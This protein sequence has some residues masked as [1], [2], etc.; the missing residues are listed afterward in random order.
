MSRHIDNKRMLPNDAINKAYD[1]Y[2]E[3]EAE[4]ASSY[5][6]EDEEDEYDDFWDEDEYDD[7]A[8]V[9]IEEALVKHLIS[10]KVIPTQFP[11]GWVH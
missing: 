1:E 2:L 4:M 11:E 5:D 8:E 10:K 3:Q 6:P 7:S 9:E